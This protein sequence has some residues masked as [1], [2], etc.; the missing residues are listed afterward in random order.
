MIQYSTKKITL[1]QI[2]QNNKDI[3]KIY[4]NFSVKYRIVAMDYDI[5]VAKSLA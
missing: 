2:L 4:T 3:L 5:C 1:H